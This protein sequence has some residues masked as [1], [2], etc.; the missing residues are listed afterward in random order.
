M[1]ALKDYLHSPEG[2]DPTGRAH[3]CGGS[4]TRRDPD[5]GTGISPRPRRV[6][7]QEFNAAPPPCRRSAPPSR[8]APSV[9]PAVAG[10]VWGLEG[11]VRSGP[12]RRTTSCRKAG[13]REGTTGTGAPPSRRHGPVPSRAGWRCGGVAGRPTRTWLRACASTALP[14]VIHPHRREKRTNNRRPLTHKACVLPGSRRGEADCGA[15]G[16]SL[17]RCAQSGEDRSPPSAHGVNPW[18]V[19]PDAAVGGTWTAAAVPARGP[20]A[21]AVPG[22]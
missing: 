18:S 19:S 22:R 4:S 12:H 17:E 14:R 9:S 11:R 5:G 3:R 7:D 13:I 21:G 1:S 16:V 10:R 6:S 15:R 8:T 2:S 20:G